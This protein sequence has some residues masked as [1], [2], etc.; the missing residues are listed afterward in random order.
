MPSPIEMTTIS[1]VLNVLHA[2]GQDNEFIFSKKGFM[3]ENGRVYRQKELEIIKTYRFEGVSDPSDEA[4]I[5]LIQT[6]D[7]LIGYSLDAYGVYSNHKD[8]IYSDFMRKMVM[9]K[10]AG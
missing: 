10:R 7:G 5:Y 3:A 9:K 8:D 4:I 2:R 1:C 6:A